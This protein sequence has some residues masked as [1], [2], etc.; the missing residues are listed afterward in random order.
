MS[1]N[2]KKDTTQYRDN[3]KKKASAH[4]KHPIHHN[5]AMQAHHL[6]SEKGVSLV[7]KIFQNKLIEF[8]YN[9]NVLDNLVFIPSTLQGACHLGVQPHRGNH[10]AF[11]TKAMSLL[12]PD[13]DDRPHPEPY[14]DMVKDLVTKVA[15]GLEFKCVKDHPH[16]K[17]LLKME[18]NQI[19]K[20]ILKRIQNNP[21]SAQLTDIAVNFVPDMPT[22][23]CG[24]DSVPAHRGRTVQ[25]A[26]QCPVG[27]DHTSKQGTKQTAEKITFPKKSTPYKLETGN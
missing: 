20:T 8:D 12:D 4:P 27:R 25:V 19:S 17:A 6:I 18:M 3:L 13:N 23:C 21:R 26:A 16:F 2:L 5:V 11:L 22:G 10:G 9:I 7:D 15:Q 24:V 14:H 1:G